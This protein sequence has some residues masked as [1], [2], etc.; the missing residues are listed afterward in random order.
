MTLDAKIQQYE[1]KH[2]TTKLGVFQE[3][4]ADLTLENYSVKF[5][6]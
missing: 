5:T 4:K 2:V 3:I 1:K 6:Y